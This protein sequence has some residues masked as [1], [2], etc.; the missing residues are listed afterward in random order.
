MFG[1]E[2]TEFGIAMLNSIDGDYY[3]NSLSSGLARAVRRMASAVES[4]NLS[5]PFYDQYSHEGVPESHV[6][7]RSNLS[8]NENTINSALE[9]FTERTDISVV[10]VID[11]MEEVFGKGFTSEDIFSIVIAVGMIVVAVVIV[12]KSFKARKA[13]KNDDAFKKL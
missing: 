9:E 5:T 7:N 11:S 10:I 8:V 1:N 2:Y 13:A 4:K 3:A 6:V 12:V